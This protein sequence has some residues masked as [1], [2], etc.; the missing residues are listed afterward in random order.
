VSKW[1]DR[2]WAIYLRLREELDEPHRTD[3][4]DLYDLM[5]NEI[6]DVRRELRDGPENL[7]LLSGEV[8]A[9]KVRW[10][11][12]YDL[13]SGVEGGALVRGTNP[14]WLAETEGLT[15]ES[16]TDCGWEGEKP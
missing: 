5:C 12:A 11:A 15:I 3:V 7:R 2:A 4:K 6:G 14:A 16:L 8:E 10:R 1:T 13:L 9:W